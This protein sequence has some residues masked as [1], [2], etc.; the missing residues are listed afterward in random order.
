MQLLKHGFATT[1]LNAQPLGLVLGPTQFLAQRLLTDSS[2]L[3][4]NLRNLLLLLQRHLRVG[5]VTEGGE[6]NEG[7]RIGLAVCHIAETGTLDGTR[8]LEK[9]SQRHRFDGILRRYGDCGTR[10]SLKGSQRRRLEFLLLRFQHLIFCL[11]LCNGSFGFFETLLQLITLAFRF[12]QLLLRLLPSSL[13][14][15]QL[16]LHFFD[17]GSLGL[18]SSLHRRNH[19][20]R[21]LLFFP[22]RFNG[23]FIYLNRFLQL[24]NLFLQ[25]TARSTLRWFLGLLHF[26]VEEVNLLVPLIEQCSEFHNLV[27]QRLHIHGFRWLCVVSFGFSFGL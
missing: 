19:I 14:L 6:G 25:L 24:G 27:F 8:S 17:L 20:G 18:L 7:S 9:V 3:E 23:H 11:T 1:E 2:L 13:V 22:K 26:L 21:L 12:Q 15:L 4:L 10:R 16:C 5:V